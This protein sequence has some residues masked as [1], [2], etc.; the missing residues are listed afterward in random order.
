MLSFLVF[1]GGQAEVLDPG[2]GVSWKAPPLMDAEKLRVGGHGLPLSERGP[3]VP[4][5]SGVAILKCVPG[6]L[7]LKP[8]GR[9]SVR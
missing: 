4:M 7:S 8:P 9:V 1:V 5:R 6:R 3:Q 2:P